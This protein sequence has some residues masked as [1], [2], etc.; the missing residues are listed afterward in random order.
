MKHPRQIAYEFVDVVPSPREEGKLYISIKYR[1]AIHN[2]FCGC[3]TKVVT[4]IRPTGW[5][6]TY[7]GD[8]VTLHPSIGNWSFNCR[9]HYW[10][11]DSQAVAAGSMSQDEIETGRRRDCV[12]KDA[13]FGDT[14]PSAPTTP[15][16]ATPT[17]KRGFW[18]WLLGW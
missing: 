16:D 1:T 7:N 11:Q 18:D 17:K 3:G 13:Y 5:R 9:S 6:L 2:C 12:A 8:T 15:A 4:P 14:A 10:I